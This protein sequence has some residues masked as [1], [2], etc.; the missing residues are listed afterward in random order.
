V[1]QLTST[2]ASD[3]TAVLQTGSGSADLQQAQFHLEQGFAVTPK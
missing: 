1:P 2:L 3:F